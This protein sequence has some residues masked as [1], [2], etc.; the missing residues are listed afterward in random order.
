MFIKYLFTLNFNLFFYF[1]LFLLFLF[2]NI[3]VK[4]YRVFIYKKII[5]K[6]T[7]SKI[8][9]VLSMCSD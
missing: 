6:K 5:N 4:F 3:F 1:L 9:V 8:M 7:L 2:N